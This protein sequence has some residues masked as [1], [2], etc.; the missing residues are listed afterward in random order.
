MLSITYQYSLGGLHILINLFSLNDK[1]SY[2]S[3]EEVFVVFK[4]YCSRDE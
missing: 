3:Q 1:L 4:G 2:I